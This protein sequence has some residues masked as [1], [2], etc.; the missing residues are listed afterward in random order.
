MKRRIF[1]STASTIGAIGAVS[2]ESV[3]SS[4]YSN[5][6]KRANIQEFS[7]EIKTVWDRF[8][9]DICWHFQDLGIDSKYAEFVTSPIQIIYNESKKV[10]FKN[11][12]GEYVSLSILEDIDKIEFHKQ[13]I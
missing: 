4:A 9:T 13:V 8:S 11:R 12:S 3:F 10:T 6:T 2:A 1:L 5:L 7:P